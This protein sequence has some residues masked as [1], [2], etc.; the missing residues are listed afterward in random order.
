MTRPAWRKPFTAFL[1]VLL[2]LFLL[3]PTKVQAYGL[4][5]HLWIG[6]RILAELQHDCVLALGKSRVVLN[7]D[8]C[9]SIR[10]N[11]AAFLSGV[12]GPDM[13]PDLITGQVTTHPGIQGGWGTRDWLRHMYAEANPGVELAFAAGYL[14][15]AASDVF[16]HTYVN[17]YAGD[18]FSLKDER[19]VERRHVLLEKYIDAKLPGFTFN[20]G[21]VKAPSRFIRD[22]LIHAPVAYASESSS[23]LAAHIQAM[24]RISNELELLIRQ[25]RQG[26]PASSFGQLKSFSGPKQATPD[27]RP[28]EDLEAE[29]LRARA[30]LGAPESGV[31]SLLGTGPALVGPSSYF[32]RQAEYASALDNLS[33]R[34]LLE[35]QQ[36]LDEAGTEYVEASNRVAIDL[37]AGND[38]PQRHYRAWW[39]CHGKAYAATLP[40]V[41][42]ASCG[43]HKGKARAKEKLLEILHDNPFLWSGYLA[44]ANLKK[45]V[46]A[47][48]KKGA[49]E[50]ADWYLTHFLDDRNTAD[51][52]GLLTTRSIDLPTEMQAAFSTT[53]DGNKPILTFK[54]IVD[55]IDADL[56]AN[57][58]GLNP[59]H[60]GPLQNALM[61]SKLSLLEP[62]RLRDLIR[63]YGAD[64]GLLTISPTSGRYS[65]LYD[66]VRSIDG[67]HQWQPFGLP[68]GRESRSGATTQLASYGYGEPGE[69]GFALFLDEE[70]RNKVFVPL[71]TGF[72]SG[73]LMHHK[74]LDRSTY[75]FAECV[76]HRFPV[77]FTADRQ[78]AKADCTCAAEDK[79]QPAYCPKKEAP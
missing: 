10:Q 69:Q 66:M 47:L 77:S 43:I 6:K 4:K 39:A 37:I 79:P 68:Y 1:P 13:Y 17:G 59:E 40:P 75:P 9:E 38:K 26:G 72:V 67:N 50:V 19:A 31:S 70:L 32:V 22:K 16:A 14:V 35:W 3:L 36:A 20:D 60:F 33:L 28:T 55:D 18:I 62:D 8:L 24:G 54:R 42:A 46:K 76:G 74:K 11:P 2:I 57:A 71:F 27:A 73:N 48:A 30:A 15:H 78:R 34:Y 44:Y 53:G 52:L 65:V 12:L 49:I 23:K 29:Y 7:N 64:P 61:L 58:A 63:D 41:I 21:E 51:L 45:S 5:T 25:R 56:G